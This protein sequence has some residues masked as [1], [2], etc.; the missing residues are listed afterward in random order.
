MT[1][2]NIKRGISIYNFQEKYYRKEMTLAD[3][4]AT[5]HRFGVTG[6]EMLSDQMIPGYPSIKYNL[7]DQFL[8]QWR[9]LMQQYPVKPI[10]FD[11][12]GETKLRKGKITPDADVV[13]E[14]VELIKTADALGFKIL[15]LT[16]HLP[17]AVVEAMIPHAEER[18]M[19]WA[20]EVH[21]PHLLT[22]EWVQKNVELALRKKTKSLGLM[23]DMGI[24]CKTIP[25]LVLDEAR[26]QGATPKIVDFMSKVYADRQIPKDLVEQVRAMGGNEADEWLALRLV[27]GVW[28]YHDPKN[29]LKYMPHIFHI[30]G[31]FYEMTEDLREPD[32]AYEA[33]M[34][35]LIEGGYDGFIMS[36]YEGQRLTHG[37]DMGYDEVEQVR[38]HQKMLSQY[39]GH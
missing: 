39:I 28:T 31:K 18:G 4:I 23:P 32:V 8:G 24:F 15:R 29:L 10:A 14:L 16:F 5:A 6:F 1:T 37:V 9:D 19:K 20:L 34:P 7:S 21:A 27:I 17:I 12:Y 13:A 11:V 2:S 3:C 33:I 35:M 22:G 25:G 38:R 26:R 30:H 36:E